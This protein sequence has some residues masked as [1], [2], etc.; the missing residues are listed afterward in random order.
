MP[1]YKIKAPDGNTYSI[2]GP[3]GATDEQVRQKVLEQHPTAAN[4][5]QL[6]AAPSRLQMFISDVSG[7]MKARQAEA[8][9]EQQ[10]ARNMPL[11]AINPLA[12]VMGFGADVKGALS[13][14]YAMGR[15]VGRQFDPT[16]GKPGSSGNEDVKYGT[17]AESLVPVPAEKLVAPAQATGRVIASALERGA[18][19]VARGMQTVATPVAKTTA[20]VLNAGKTAEAAV[21]DVRQ[22]A[23]AAALERSDVAKRSETTAAVRA[24]RAQ[25]GE[26]AYQR[27][28][29]NISPIGVGNITSMSERGRGAQS[30]AQ[31]AAEVANTERRAA[32]DNLTNAIDDVVKTNESQGVFIN[33]TPQARR[34]LSEVQE[35]LSPN[36]ASSPTAA[37]RPTSGQARAYQMVKDALENRTVPLTAEQA[38]EATDL[39][40]LVKAIKQ[41]DGTELYY[42]TFKTPLEAVTNLRRWFG[43]AAYGKAEISGFEGVNAE[44]FRDLNSKLRSIEDAYTNNLT[45]DQRAAYK[46]A[47]ENVD[48]FRIGVG[49]KLTATEGVT[50]ANKVTAAGANRAIVSGGADAYAQFKSMDPDAARKFA[51]DLVETALYDP[52]S[53]GPLKYSRAAQKV[54]PNTPL[55]DIVNEIPEL[56]TRVQQHLQQLQDAEMAG[57]QAKE[58]GQ[59]YTRASKAESAAK[60]ARQKY[61]STII[62]LKNA[63]DKQV[64]SE[65]EQLFNQLA[66][67]GKITPEQH[68]KFL[69]EIRSAS[70]A[71]QYKN[72]R[73]NAIKFAISAAGLGAAGRAGV[74]VA[75]VLGQ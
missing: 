47:L 14:V 29:E 36:P 17:L 8:A 45:A 50:N 33:D 75:N 31:S 9:Q 73:D 32:F 5:T 57:V 10:A 3:E 55:G 40:Y 66:S 74:Q 30:A 22:Q 18:A 28:A 41:K 70:S 24:R 1:V 42:R 4:P 39:G 27:E 56:K 62:Q 15:A 13:P 20:K 34:V 59:E 54:G 68:D 6:K 64:L 26:A 67:D 7:L 48:K 44:T 53:R 25:A 61:Q 2:N 19:P 69:K 71:V 49:K 23:L 21:A 46:A 16:Y 58:F 11:S 51:N 63:P 72:V 12:A 52:V 35:S 60:A 38:K 65:A 43:D 37:P